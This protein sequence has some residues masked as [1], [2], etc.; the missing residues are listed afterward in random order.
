VLAV[1]VGIAIARWLGLFEPRA[2]GTRVPTRRRG[3]IL[4]LSVVAIV[5]V[6]ALAFLGVST[7]STDGEISRSPLTRP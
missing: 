4:G 2:E 7:G 3:L 6:F 1:V 5:L